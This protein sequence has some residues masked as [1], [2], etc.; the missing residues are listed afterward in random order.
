MLFVLQSWILFTFIHFITTMPTKPKEK[1]RIKEGNKI[2]FWW[3]RLDTFHRLWLEG[4]VGSTLST[5][6]RKWASELCGNHMQGEHIDS[7]TTC[8]Y[9]M[10]PRVN[11]ISVFVWLCQYW[12]LTEDLLCKLLFF[13][14]ERKKKQRVRTFEWPLPKWCFVGCFAGDSLQ[15]GSGMTGCETPR[16][17]GGGGGTS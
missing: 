5:Q 9:H 11:L 16:C 13:L 6:P 14:C 17:G 7:F 2:G 1:N 12:P 8:F 15:S 3:N 4:C 10:G